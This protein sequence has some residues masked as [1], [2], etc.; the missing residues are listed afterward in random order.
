M[1]EIVRKFLEI[2][3][4]RQEKYARFVETASLNVIYNKPK[5]EIYCSLLNKINVSLLISVII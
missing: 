5:C 4:R 1:A 3:R 2:T